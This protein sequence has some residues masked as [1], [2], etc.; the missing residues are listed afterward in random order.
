MNSEIWDVNPYRR[1]FA[2]RELVSAHYFSTRW[3]TEAEW[4]NYPFSQIYL[5]LRGTATYQTETATYPM[6]PGMMCYAPSDTAFTFAWEGDVEF[7]LISFVC[8]S[9]AMALFSRGPILLGEEEQGTLLDVIKTAARICDNPK[10]RTAS[11]IEMFI[12]PN[13]PDVVSGFIY[14]SMER[15]LSMVYCRV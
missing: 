11:H 9:E 12:L 8:H 3:N 15:F 10:E 2:L 4:G 7:G 6:A 14:A 13:T 5:L 1:T